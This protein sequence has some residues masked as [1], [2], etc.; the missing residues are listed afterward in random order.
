[1][2]FILSDNPWVHS[3]NIH[4]KSIQS[5]QIIAYSV[6]KWALSQLWVNPNRQLSTTQMLI[7]F[8]PYILSE[9]GKT[10]G[11]AKARKLVVQGELF[12]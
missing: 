8:P 1:M 5:E 9:T 2:N 12:D 10:Q 11:K 6:H 3:V 4:V 7:H